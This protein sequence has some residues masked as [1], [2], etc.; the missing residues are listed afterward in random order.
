MTETLFDFLTPSAPDISGLR[1]IPD[2]INQDQENFL[3]NIIDQESWSH[4]LKRRVQHY[5]YRYDYKARSVTEESFLGPLPDW[6]ATLARRL[7]DEGVFD[8]VPDQVIVNE[9]LKGQGISSHIDCVPCFGEKVASLSLGS[10]CVM[11]FENSD[12]SIRKEIFLQPRS[13]IVLTG[14]AR[15]EWSHAIPARKSDHFNGQKYMRKRRVS[16]TFRNV[17]SSH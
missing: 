6:I 7:C 5:G 4:D 1:Y 14:A 9:Y 15:Y 8:C 10:S 17:I 12:R 13:L 3:L 11:Q 16:L 2:F